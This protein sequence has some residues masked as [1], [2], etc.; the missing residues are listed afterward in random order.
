MLIN[1]ALSFGGIFGI[2]LIIKWVFN[3]SNLKGNQHLVTNNSAEELLKLRYVKGEISHQEYQTI[4]T[5]IKE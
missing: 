2:F 3:N 1:F 5:T 4:L